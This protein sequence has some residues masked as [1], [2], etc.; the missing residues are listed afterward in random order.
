MCALLLYTFFF[1]F[2]RLLV[3]VFGLLMKDHLV[4]NLMSVL[5]VE[6]FGQQPLHVY[7]GGA[8]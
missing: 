7:I 2:A 5:T 1:C 6:N 8:L 3:D 4:G